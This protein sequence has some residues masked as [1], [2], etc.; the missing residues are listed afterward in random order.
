[1]KKAGNRCELAGYEG[2]AHGFFNSA[3]YAETLAEADKFLVSLGYLAP[4]A[5]QAAQ[6]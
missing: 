6:P 4:A 3:R 1:M 2:Q 5:H